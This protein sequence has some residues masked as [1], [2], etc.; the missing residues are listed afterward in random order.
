MGGGKRRKG[1]TFGWG[2]IGGCGDG[3]D[4]MG[5]D[6]CNVMWCDV[7]CGWN[8]CDVDVDVNSKEKI[9]PFLPDL[10]RDGL[11]MRERERGSYFL[12]FR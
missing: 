6:G 8:G 4:G 10:G 9:N 7:M 11:R 2:A 12:G 5:W 3:M 1:G